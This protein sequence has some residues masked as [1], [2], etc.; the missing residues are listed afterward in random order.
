MSIWT[1]SNWKMARGVS[2]GTKIA[3]VTVASMTLA[4]VGAYHSLSHSFAAT[5]LSAK[6]DH[7]RATSS[8]FTSSASAAVAFE[9]R[10]VLQQTL[11]HL[12]QNADVLF[13][14]VWS[15]TSGA[16]GEQLGHY[17]RA[18]HTGQIELMPVETPKLE[19]S[20]ESLSLTAPVRNQAG[21]VIAHGLIVFS[22]ADENTK[23]TATRQRVLLTSFGVAAAVLLS[24]LVVS[25]RTV[26]VPLK[27]LQKGVRQLEC[28]ELPAFDA[29]S[30]DEVGELASALHRMALAIRE[31][32][33]EIKG[34]NRDIRLVM[35]NL[36]QG[37][38]TLDEDGILSDNYSRLV[39]QWF[40]KPAAAEPFATYLARVD[41]GFADWFAESFLQMKGC[42]IPI[43]LALAQFPKRLKL[44]ATTWLF[45]YRPLLVDGDRLEN[46]VIVITDVTPTL[47]KQRLEREQQE[48]VAAFTQATSQ[49]Q[50]FAAFLNEAEALVRGVECSG[51]DDF[52]LARRHLHTLKGVFGIVEAHSLVD[53]CHELEGQLCE[54]NRV[55][56][57]EEKQE[58][59]ARWNHYEARSRSFVVADENCILLER[60]SYLAFLEALRS[61]VP[62]CELLEQAATWEFEDAQQ[63]LETLGDHARA[64]AGRL[65]KGS[66]DVQIESSGLRLP[67]NA[68]GELWNVLVHVVR[69]A[70]D[71]GLESA[72]DRE[73]LGKPTRG[74]LTL[75][76]QLTDGMLAVAISDDG[77]GI[78]WERVRQRA[79]Q[80]GLPTETDAD[81]EKALFSDGLTTRNDTTEI[82]GRGI[83]TAALS[84]SIRSL[85]GRIELE[86][87]AGQGTTLRCSIP[88]RSIFGS[89]ADMVGAPE[90]ATFADELADEPRHSRDH[91]QR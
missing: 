30:D 59:R 79:R 81:L 54:L 58:L 1:R 64:L 78:D 29:S 75:S 7:A 72:P 89:G 34:R 37:V 4:S 51:P 87:V 14:G 6:G 38:L 62:H 22:L 91:R 15:G 32:E 52:V 55:P 43:E 63:H 26:V 25:R 61:D 2:V 40:G 66:I 20:T 46:L 69:N 77:R 16:V 35:D 42:I 60:N 80:L 76:T 18:G 9:N 83:G 73:A 86:S 23:I 57:T 65:G 33:E 28:G 10:D 11:E 12:A 88:S 45:E 44:G 70:V 49:R 8:L 68:C 71:H 74:R 5:L 48:I 39:E 19:W 24:L 85:G 31:R 90:R 3:T 13:A 41:V 84:S 53:F 56:S 21:Q 67:P 17:S 47:E 82:S 50:R 27:R 36:G